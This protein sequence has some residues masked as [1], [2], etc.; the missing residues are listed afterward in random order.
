MVFI[1][2]KTGTLKVGSIVHIHITALYHRLI[3]IPHQ[4]NHTLGVLQ[5]TSFRIGFTAHFD[6]ELIY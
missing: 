1:A 2:P 3:N 4:A 5:Q 6:P